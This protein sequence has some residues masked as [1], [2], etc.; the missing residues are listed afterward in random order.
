M[1]KLKLTGQNLGRALTLE[2]GVLEF[3]ELFCL[4]AKRPILKLKIYPKQLFGSRLLH[5]IALVLNLSMQD[6][7]F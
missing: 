3:Q 5:P 7:M 6:Q 4:T 2:W 1:E